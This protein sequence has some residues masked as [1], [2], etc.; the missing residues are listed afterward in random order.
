MKKAALCIIILISCLALLLRPDIAAEAV[1][2]SLKTVVSRIIPSLFP[3]MVLSEMMISS[4]CGTSTNKKNTLLSVISAVALGNISGF[5]VGAKNSARLCETGVLSRKEAL[6]CAIISGNAG[7]SFVISFVGANL[8][9]NKRLGL[10]IY[11]SQLTASLISAMIASVMIKEKRVFNA[12]PVFDGKNNRTSF[13]EAFTS[14]VSGAALSSLSVAAF[15]TT[16]GVI[17]KYVLLLAE[18][19][20]DSKLVLSIISSVLEISNGCLASMSLKAPASYVM[21]SFCIGFSGLSVMF[22][23]IIYLR[24]QSINII[25]FVAFKFLQGVL[26]AVITY[27]AVKLLPDVLEVYSAQNVGLN[28]NRVLSY[29]VLAVCFGYFLFHIRK[30]FTKI[31]IQKRKDL[32]SDKI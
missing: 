13:S 20:T 21:C 16:F 26:S 24:R 4:F 8:F 3:F 25:K 9:S 17:I 28:Q 29:L 10:I 11:L 2:S 5:P 18:T 12:V 30:I 15:I 23:S 22:Q 1:T 7:A 6:L 14:S 32:I 31:N 27:L 19:F